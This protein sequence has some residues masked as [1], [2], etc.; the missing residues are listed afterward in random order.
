[1][2]VR[3]VCFDLGGVVVR[4]CRS[5]DEG[6]LAAGVEIRD[7]R[8]TPEQEERRRAA[9]DAYQRGELECDAF[10][11][12]VADT[13]NGVYAPEEV[14]RVHDAWII[15]EYEGVG[16]LVARLH[17][18]RLAT[19]C[20]SNTNPGHW[21]RLR[22]WPAVAALGARY[23][24]HQMRLLKPDERIYRAFEEAA[25]AR[26]R[27]ILFFEDTPENAETARAVGWRAEVVD[28]AEETAPQIEHHLAAHGVR[29]GALR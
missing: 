16:D 21:R 25:G 15:R 29:L 13:F 22:E 23:A 9:V 3:L 28:P 10:F 17:D 6:C 26:G 19:A 12:A 1:M 7:R 8:R 20:L 5:W 14:R 11:A 24:S 4:L 2:N 18:A 27:E